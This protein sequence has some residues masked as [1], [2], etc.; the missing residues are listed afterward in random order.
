MTETVPER[1]RFFVFFSTVACFI[2]LL[3]IGT[4]RGPGREGRASY[5][6]GQVGQADLSSL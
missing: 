3:G 4:S 2:K 1:A 5:G 6:T